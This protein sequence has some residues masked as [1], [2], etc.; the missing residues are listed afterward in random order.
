MVLRGNDSTATIRSRDAGSRMDCF[1]SKWSGARM[2]LWSVAAVVVVGQLCSGVVLAERYTVDK[3][4]FEV[5][6]VPEAPEIMLGEPTRIAFKVTNLSD[7]P[8]AA[9]IKT[10]SPGARPY[11]YNVKVVTA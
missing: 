11:T 9:T 10:A 1:N 2:K 6:A 5:S 3:A 7:R 8:M 4:T